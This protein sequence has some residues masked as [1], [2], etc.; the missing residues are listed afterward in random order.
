M[1]QALLAPRLLWAK[2]TGA[3][4]DLGVF[5]PKV[6]AAKILSA[7]SLKS[8]AGDPV[9]VGHSSCT[10]I[11]KCPA[12]RSFLASSGSATQRWR[13]R[14]RAANPGHTKGEREGSSNH[15]GPGPTTPI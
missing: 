3:R 4:G 2:D 9:P 13:A 8:R 5:H 6:G 7:L 11:R 12:L 15:S 1:V 14:G 10:A